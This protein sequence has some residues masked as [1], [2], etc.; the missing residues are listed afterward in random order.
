MGLKLQ[1]V[2]ASA[3]WR[4]VADSF[5]EYFRH[6][7]VYVGMFVTFLLA[8]IGL[9]VVFSVASSISPLLLT[10]G[11]VVMV[12]ITP[13]LTLAYMMGVHDSLQGR[14]LHTGIYFRPWLQREPDRRKALSVL[15]LA[16]AVATF[17]ALAMAG[18]LNDDNVAMRQMREAMGNDK[19][20]QEELL[21][22]LESD[23]ATELR[24]RFLIAISVVSIPFWFAPALVFW[25]GQSAGQAL[26]SS[27]LA[28]WRARGAF[29]IY[30]LCSLGAV[31]AIGLVMQLLGMLL[32]P[33]FVSLLLMPLVLM[34][35]AIFYISVYFSF[36]DCFGEP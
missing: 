17:A 11:T 24:L 12:G 31:M 27:V 36:R 15:M 10:A 20:T 22:V 14:F 32:G 25:S 19:T 9:L 34:L 18:V 3:G 4:W 28:L 33:A 2:P 8:N 30:T 29:A 13:L 16:F 26:F 23:A 5:T 7:V 6:P 21:R 1:D 35:P